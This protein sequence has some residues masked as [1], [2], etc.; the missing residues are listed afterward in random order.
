M[1]VRL[2]GDHGQALLESSKICLVNATATGCEILKNLI[3][4][5][6]GSF[7]II[8]DGLVTEQDLGNKSVIIS[9]KRFRYPIEHGILNT[10]FISGFI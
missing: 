8:D 7:N 9:N 4:P 6:V 1:L 5:G 10:A 2:W 3:L